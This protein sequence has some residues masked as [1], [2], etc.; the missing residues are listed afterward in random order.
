MTRM[1]AL[2][3]GSA[4]AA[5]T[6]LSAVAV[7]AAPSS[8]AGPAHADMAGGPAHHGVHAVRGEGHGWRGRHSHEARGDFCS[9]RAGGMMERRLGLIEGL[10][11]LSTDQ[12]AALD[13]LKTAMKSGRETIEKSCE[14][15]KEGG[16]PKTAIEG[17]TRFEEAMS[18]RLEAMRS[19]KP[20]FEKFYTTLSEKQQKA[21]DDLF[22]RR[23]HRG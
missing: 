21:I 3:A 18:T 15:R 10:M 7:T 22:T 5:I 2:L 16:R 4:I 6:T 1:K 13:E 20:A 19:V 17:F 14:A 9:R 8:G 23:G 12:Q 11:D